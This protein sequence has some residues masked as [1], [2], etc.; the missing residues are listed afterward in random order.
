MV[1]PIID[2]VIIGTV[3][4]DSVET[5]FG[6]HEDILGG[7]AT[8]A[9]YAASFFVDPGIVSIVGEDFPEEHLQ[10][11]TDKGVDIAGI[12][13]QGKTFRW[14]GF[15]EFDM[16]EAKTRTTD[17]NCL[18]EFNPVLP[19]KYKHS[20]YVFLANIDPELQLK[21]INQLTQENPFIV[22]DTMNFWIESKKEKLI[23]VIQKATILLINDAEARM[24]FKTPNLFQ[25]AQ[26]ALKLG[27]KAIVIKKGEHG[28]MLFT[29]DGAETK[30]FNAPAYPLEVVKDPTGC[31][32]TF[33][34]TFTAYLAKSGN[35]GE[36]NLRKAVVFGTAMAS[37]NAEEFSLNK[38][39]T[40]TLQDVEGR[41]RTLKTIR[42]F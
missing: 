3:A 29:R 5:P 1:D 9:S 14:S 32:D 31:G 16:N 10:L 26:Q 42:E 27:P 40:A 28:A 36:H 30:Y 39:K 33:G 37:I 19:E 13:K 20:K 34:G 22:M 41:I 7:A 12:K 38:L 18:A 24:L 2:M 15:Y 4:L 8:Y 25:A 11:L 21:V 35:Q 17:L 6:K 23:E